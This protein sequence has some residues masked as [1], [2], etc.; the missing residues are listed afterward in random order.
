MVDLNPH[1]ISELNTGNPLNQ[2]VDGVDF[3]HTGLFKALQQIGTG[4]F[5]IRDNTNDFDIT[6]SSLNPVVSVAAGSY[7]DNGEKKTASAQTFDNTDFTFTTSKAYY[8]IVIDS[9]GT[10]AL[11]VPDGADKVAEHDL[12]DT[13]IAM[14]EIADDTTF[15]S[16]KVQ[17]FTTD[18]TKNSLSIGQN[19]GGS[20][21]IEEG[22]ITAPTGATGQ[23]ID[24][25]TVTTDSDIRITP[26]G[27]GKIVLDSLNWP[28]SDGAANQFL[29]TD[30]SNQLSF[31]TV[32][33]T[34]KQDVISGD[35]LTAATV[36]TDDKVLIQDTD[37]ADNLKTVTTQSIANLYNETDTLDSVVSKGDTTTRNISVGV[38]TVDGL[39]NEGK[40]TIVP[41]DPTNA[42]IDLGLAN[43][44]NTVYY[45][46][47]NAGPIM[48][49]ANGANG[50]I[51]HI[52]N[53]DTVNQVVI[54]T[55]VPIDGAGA[56]EDRRRTSSTQITLLA[57]EGITLQYVDDVSG[58]SAGWY[59]LDTDTN[60]T[61]GISNVVEDTTPQLGG[62]L[63]VNGNDIVSASNGDITITP[64]G[65][66]QIVLD[67][68]NWPTADGSAD[69]V[70]KT[71]GAGQ[72]SFVDGGGSVGVTKLD[73]IASDVA[74]TAGNW[75]TIDFSDTSRW[76]ETG[77]AGVLTLGSG[78]NAGNIT[79]G[80]A[81][82][83]YLVIV[84]LWMISTPS[85]GATGNGLWIVR[86][87]YTPTQDGG[88]FYHREQEYTNNAQ[89]AIV[90]NVQFTVAGGT[91]I[92][93]IEYYYNLH[94]FQYRGNAIN[95]TRVSFLE[96]VRLR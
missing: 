1:Y 56:A 82:E 9:T 91:T 72:L 60:A 29:K 42:N 59:I 50:Q 63:D 83:L 54:N 80:S 79:V 43:Y 95:T 19:N 16:R 61:S 89:S 37:D 27:N 20:S 53:S 31:A 36:A 40:T 47:G 45:I 17:Y 30:G 96:F 21:Y 8:L 48:S 73:C 69:Q 77:D 7:F 11:R 74:Q 64:D 65:T 10:I 70:L 26:N 87:N 81:G 4:N 32:D 68:L 49:L 71:D 18:K 28:T 62:N 3:P 76:T 52:K 57:T 38:A 67:G 41:I 44:G 90:A 5:V 66:G 34:S 78:A 92:D 35:T 23:G 75:I 85:P 6:Q 15:G 93:S 94:N 86:G 13:I 55:S 25:E 84:H 88:A 24:I 51:I 14:I 2:I 39:T 46:D 33:L 12:G 58:I 22:K